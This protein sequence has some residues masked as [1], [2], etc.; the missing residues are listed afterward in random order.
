MQKIV[1]ELLHRE[2]CRRQNCQVKLKIFAILFAFKIDPVKVDSQSTVFTSSQISA[3]C[4]YVCVFVCVCGER[5]KMMN[6]GA[7]GK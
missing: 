6:N 3:L 4:V 2:H 5:K 7:K 1:L